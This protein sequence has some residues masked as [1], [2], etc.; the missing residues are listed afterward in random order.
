MAKGTKEELAPASPVA[1][2]RAGINSEL[3]ELGL[4]GL[5]RERRVKKYSHKLHL[6]VVTVFTRPYQ[7]LPERLAFRRAWNVKQNCTSDCPKN[8]LHR[9]HLALPSRRD[10]RFHMELDDAP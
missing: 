7:S 9:F 1:L 8:H 10:N 4:D 5:G 2:G 3:S 6:L